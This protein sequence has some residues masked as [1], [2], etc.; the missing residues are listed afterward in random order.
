MVGLH[1][2]RTHE[3]PILLVFIFFL[4]IQRRIETL[5]MEPI[6]AKLTLD[7]FLLWLMFLLAMAVESFV[8][9]IVLVLYVV[10]LLFGK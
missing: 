5:G 9:V 10:V 4:D 8:V 6:L 7:H 1:T 2:I 3:Q